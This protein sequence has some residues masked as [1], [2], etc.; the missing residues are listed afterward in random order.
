MKNLTK[1]FAAA[2]CGLSMLFAC[3]KQELVENPYFVLSTE[4]G[5][6]TLMAFGET[7]NYTQEVQYFRYA[8]AAVAA[9]SVLKSQR[10]RISSNCDWSIVPVSD[11]QD[12]VQP[13]PEQGGSQ[14]GL[15]FF[16]VDR[17][18]DM[19]S[20]RLAGYKFVINDGLND[21][22]VG[23]SFM[24]HQVNAKP[25]LEANVK[26]IEIAAAGANANVTVTSNVAWTYR[27][28]ASE[29]YASEDPE[30][31]TVDKTKLQY[32]DADSTILTLKNKISIGCP[33]NSEGSI[34]GFSIIISATDESLNL[35]P[36]VIPVVQYGVSGELTGFPVSWNAANNNFPKWPSASNAVPT[37]DPKEGAGSI[38]FYRADVPGLDRAA[39]TCD[40]SGSNPRVNGAWPG[41]Y[42]EFTAD[43]PVSAGS[44]IKLQFEA[45]ISGSG[46][47]H[48]RLEYFDGEEWQVCGKLQELN[49][50]DGTPVRF[51]HDMYPGGSADDYNHIISAVVKF[52]KTVS[53]AKFR[54]YV[55]SNII[56]SS[57]LQMEKPTTASARLDFS[58]AATGTEPIISCVA[59]GGEELIYG[60]VQCSEELLLFEGTPAGPKKFK[61]S[62]DQEIKISANVPWLSVTPEAIDAF[63]EK[64]VSVTAEASTL[65]TLRE[66]LVVITSGMTK[67]N[68]R[69]VQSAAGAELDPLISIVGGNTKEIDYDVLSFKVKVQT[70]T[71]Y[72]V[73]IPAEVDWIATEPFE[74]KAG[75]VV[76]EV[77]L[78][79]KANA[80]AEPRSAT[81]QFVNEANGIVCPLTIVQAGAPA[82]KTMTIAWTFS[83]D[84]MANYKD[85]FEKSNSF[86]AQKGTGFLSWVD[87][88][89]NVAL[90]QEKNKKKSRVIGGTGEPYITGG[91]PGDYWEFSIPGI[92][93]PAGS[94]VTFTGMTRCSGTGHKYWIMM[95]EDNGVWKNFKEPSTETET[96][97]NAQ[98]THVLGSSNIEVKE[99]FKLT[100]DMTNGTIKIRMKIVANWQVNGG[101]LAAP[102]GGTARW[103]VP[104]GTTDGPVITIEE[105][106]PVLK[107]KWNFDADPAKDP[108]VATFGGTTG[109]FKNTAGDN[110]MYIDTDSKLSVG[111]GK[112][113]YVQVDKTGFAG[114]DNPKYYVGGTGHPYMTGAWPD[115]YWQF[116]ATDG[117]EY[118]AGTK[119]HIKYLT[120]ISATGQKY[121]VLEAWDG[122]AWQPATALQTETETGNN[123]QYNFINPTSNAEVE[124]T[125]TLAKPCTEMQFRMRCVANWQ[126]NG[127]GAL[128]SPNGGTVRLASAAVD[129]EYVST[130]PVFEVVE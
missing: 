98:Y 7:L 31:W 115:D 71:E 90:D 76:E 99:S 18:N 38:C 96:G 87:D 42:F 39:S 119:L 68:I 26:N 30:F 55:A 67:K 23:G 20:D 17:N 10:F 16:R 69:V 41:D 63:D 28:E 6:D 60:D 34:R 2:V 59:A 117:V 104:S 84:D 15:I 121:W 21:R 37:L 66:G 48:W 51:T 105:P 109:T 11:D 46:C 54:Y 129:G 13:F 61:V 112:I 74:T 110:G 32:E 47:R 101:A 25:R 82:S 102:N 22:E 4:S 118:P 36:I 128:A 92:T 64:E 106:K 97:T 91:W 40:V 124:H 79:T 50:P 24:I 113:T 43:A 8:S 19:S 35:K 73:V 81:I 5:A 1:I 125:W 88:P 57:G 65:S 33:D 130:S 89:A 53:Q 85:A 49:A 127:K 56:A 9:D 93:A 83:A 116:T 70:N 111:S 100:S 123:V 107:A 52:P 122:E 126:S 77:E 80:D 3:Q 94:K 86:P 108:Y 14:D 44:L 29:E 62:S 12:W 27:L 103:S 95:Y 72:E 75:V 78:Y 120:R 58:G 45:R 114:T